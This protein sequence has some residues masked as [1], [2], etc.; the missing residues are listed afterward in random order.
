LN[1]Q[2]YRQAETEFFKE[3]KKW[4]LSVSVGDASSAMEVCKHRGGAE[5]NLTLVKG[6]V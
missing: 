1:L 2:E 3:M 4:L 5:K 6:S